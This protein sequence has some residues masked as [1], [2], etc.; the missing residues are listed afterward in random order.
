VVLVLMALIACAPAARGQGLVEGAEGVAATIVT[1]SSQVRFTSPPCFSTITD[2]IVVSNSGTDSLV[3][4]PRLIG[5]AAADF[6]IAP[7]HNLRFAV[8]PGGRLTL[9]IRFA[10]LGPG[11]GTALLE[12]ASNDPAPDR[13]TIWLPMAARGPIGQAL[14]DPA[15]AGFSDVCVGSRRELPIQIHY[16]GDVE[17][18]IV[19]VERLGSGPAAFDFSFPPPVTLPITLAIPT[20][21][22]LLQVGFTPP[23]P[24]VFTDSFKIVTGPCDSALLLVVRGNGVDTRAAVAPDTIDFG[25]VPV[26]GSAARSVTMLNTGASAGAVTGIPTSGASFVPPLSLIGGTIA[27]GDSAHGNAVFTPTAV[28]EMSGTFCIIFGV[29][30]P[31]T[32]CVAVRGR[33]VA[34]SLVTSRDSLL[35]YAD[36]CADPMPPVHDTFAL[37]NLGNTDLRVTGII[38]ANNLVTAAPLRPLPLDLA[39]GDSLRVAVAWSSTAPPGTTLVDRITVVTSDP[40]VS[41]SVAVVMRRELAQLA[42]A[43]V[44]GGPLPDVIDLG[45]IPP[46]DTA[47]RRVTILLRNGGG[48]AERVSASFTAGS[49][50]A[51]DAASYLLPALSESRAVIT[52]DPSIGSSE[53]DTLL[54]R[55]ERCGETRLIPFRVQRLRQLVVSASSLDFGD[56]RVG[57][58]SALTFTLANVSSSPITIG[59][60]ALPA[61]FTIAAPPLP[62]TIAPLTTVTLT[63][64]FQPADTGPAIGELRMVQSLPCPDTSAIPLSG[65]GHRDRV[66]VSIPSTLRGAP[67]E[68]IAIPILADDPPTLLRAGA[69]SLTAT[70]RLRRSLLVPL[71][72]RGASGS[73][74]SRTITATDIEGDD[75]TITIAIDGTD[76]PGGSDTLALLDA[77][78]LLGDT[79]STAI[80]ID[81]VSFGGGRP[82]DVA[83]SDGLFTLEGLCVS[84]GERLV[85][86]GSFGLK[87]AL[88]NPS[89]GATGILFETIESGTVSLTVHDERGRE[90]APLLRGVELPV[91]AHRIAWSC[92]DLPSGTYEVVLT[93]LMGR[94]HLRLIVVR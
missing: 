91:G 92:G 15:I 1:D 71:R 40:N 84:G 81:T 65:R 32:V 66:I 70:L 64:R 26:G 48:L 28:G 76:M 52:Y 58:D 57:D 79:T 90:V 94:S 19:S 53:L 11:L 49:G 2:S 46:C 13:D 60:L 89:N 80:A 34:A 9:F 33:G 85:T 77:L 35:L 42:Y 72:L 82:I 43:A 24:G 88:P 55:G 7:P 36:S 50:F 54:L 21:G 59:E 68:E 12:L 8:P 16:S 30:C 17:G 44:D 41:P 14:L 47:I 29:L 22:A 6:V 3:V 61:P 31:D 38:I 23:G 39:P 67:G 51:S 25:D 5:P 56:L 75:R 18:T 45:S 93:S 27:P 37:R 63:V 86:A 20:G 10:P 62:F 73:S 69:G 87:A 78:V 74:V 83:T 4:R